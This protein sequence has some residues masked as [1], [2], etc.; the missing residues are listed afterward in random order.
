LPEDLKR[1]AQTTKLSGLQEFI[2]SQS[3]NVD[4]LL[5]G[6]QIWPAEEGITY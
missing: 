6:D 2:K 4:L 5:E 3:E 1:L